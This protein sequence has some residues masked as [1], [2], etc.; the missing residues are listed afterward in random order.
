MTLAVESRRINRDMDRIL[1]QSRISDEVPVRIHTRE[2]DAG[3]SPELH[4]AFIRYIGQVCQC[5][6]KAD[7]ED[8][9]DFGCRPDEER[10]FHLTRSKMHPQRLKRAFRQLRSIAPREYDACYLIAALGFTWHGALDKLNADN[11]SRGRDEYSEADFTVLTIAGF[12][13]LTASY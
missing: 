7:P 10:R 2:T 1:Q 4:E 8:P 13:K 12:S 5:G 9:N 11:L 6:R 3:G